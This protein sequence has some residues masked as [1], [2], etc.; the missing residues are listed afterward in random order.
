[1]KYRWESDVSLNPDAAEIKDVIH[2][3]RKHLHCQFELGDFL[4]AEA[5]K[6]S[7]GSTGG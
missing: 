2:K 1:M 6:A 3:S 7:E 5:E 4:P